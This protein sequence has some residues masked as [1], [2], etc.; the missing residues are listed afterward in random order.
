MGLNIKNAEAER[1]VRQLA[2]AT[3][4][5]VTQAVSVAARERLERV[6]SHQSGDAERRKARILAIAHDAAKRW[7]AEHRT[8]D[9]GDLLYNE[10]GLPR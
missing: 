9:H 2:A 1:L 10:M 8:V 4:E 3:G 5:S 7:P 6:E